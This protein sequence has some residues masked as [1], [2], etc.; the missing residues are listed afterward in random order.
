MIRKLLFWVNSCAGGSVQRIWGS[1]EECAA[2]GILFSLFFVRTWFL[3]SCHVQVTSPSCW[4]VSAQ[5]EWAVLLRSFQSLPTLLK[6]WLLTW[7]FFK[8]AAPLLGCWLNK[9]YPRSFPG[10]CHFWERSLSLELHRA[11]AREYLWFLLL[12]LNTDEGGKKESRCIKNKQFWGVETSRNIL[13]ALVIVH[14]HFLETVCPQGSFMA[15]SME[16]AGRAGLCHTWIQFLSLIPSIGSWNSL[17][18]GFLTDQQ[19]DQIGALCT[20]VWFFWCSVTTKRRFLCHH[21]T[22]ENPPGFWK[23]V[24]FYFIFFSD[25]W[26]SCAVEGMSGLGSKKE[27]SVK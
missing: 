22:V 13:S 4:D 6:E 17:S 27:K 26:G 3:G 8:A 10:L 14:G 16:A 23:W 20:A 1:V 2:L 5:A 15:W 18:G 9:T 25:T 7:L 24:L 21:W 11:W 12:K 19:F